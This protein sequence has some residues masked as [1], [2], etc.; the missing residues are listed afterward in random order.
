M[1]YL[2]KVLPPLKWSGSIVYLYIK[3]WLY[4]ETV[5]QLMLCLNI[6][7]KLLLAHWISRKY[8]NQNVIRPFPPRDTLKACLYMT[9]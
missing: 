6:S 2:K 1:L 9:I 3:L 7:R 4:N 5:K 8:K